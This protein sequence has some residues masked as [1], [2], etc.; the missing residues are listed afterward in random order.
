MIAT[1]IPLGVLV[2]SAAL[3]VT[4]FRVYRRQQRRLRQLELLYGSMRAIQGA[5]SLR[6]AVRELLR[7]ART[8]VPAEVAALLLVPGAASPC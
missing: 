4:G 5:P 1:A 6:M 2:A 7:A 3:G 8:I